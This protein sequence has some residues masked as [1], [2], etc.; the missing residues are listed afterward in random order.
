MKT[1]GLDPLPIPDI[2]I[3]YSLDKVGLLLLLA[4]EVYTFTVGKGVIVV[5]VTT[6]RLLLL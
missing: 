1:I 4:V 2:K 3:P 6:S 5:L